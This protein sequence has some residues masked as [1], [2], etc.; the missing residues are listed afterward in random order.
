M[1]STVGD[2]TVF[3]NTSATDVSGPRD[4]TVAGTATG[5]AE[6]TAP[7]RRRN[8]SPAS[9]WSGRRGQPGPTVVVR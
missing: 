5:T 2:G 3:L 7:A 8:R 9:S 4:E 1:R 6:E